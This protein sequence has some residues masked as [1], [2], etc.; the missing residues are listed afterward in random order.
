M[1]L[2]EGISARGDNRLLGTNMDINIADTAKHFKDLSSVIS[3]VQLILN[4]YQLLASTHILRCHHAQERSN[5]CGCTKVA[6][7]LK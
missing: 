5:V 4:A 7:V 6:H 2:I 1:A 3:Q